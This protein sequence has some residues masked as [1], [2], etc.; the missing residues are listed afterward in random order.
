MSNKCTLRPPLLGENNKQ[1]GIYC[2]NNLE[3][4]YTKVDAGELSELIVDRFLD[5][6]K[7]EE[8]E[9]A[10]QK[11][12]TKIEFGGHIIITHVNIR[13]VASSILNQSV[14]LKLLN[15]ILYKMGNQCAMDSLFVQSILEN[16]G[17]EIVAKQVNLFTHTI[18]ARRNG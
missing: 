7:L 3:D 17:L 14:D 9:A 1:V 13:M 10:L 4:V 6:L 11:L 16:L 8:V 2:F 18:I 12:A 5:T 15:D